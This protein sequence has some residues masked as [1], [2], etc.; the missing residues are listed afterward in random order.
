VEKKNQ[1]N[2]KGREVVDKVKYN[3]KNDR[4]C[5]FNVCIKKTNLKR[6]K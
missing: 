3:R 4:D 1:R 6:K 5:I 2:Y